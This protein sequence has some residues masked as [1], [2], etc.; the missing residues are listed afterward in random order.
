MSASRNSIYKVRPATRAA[1]KKPLAPGSLMTAPFVLL[2][3]FGVPVTAA[4]VRP[5]A[6]LGRDA[7]GT[8]PSE[9]TM[10]DALPAAPAG[11]GTDPEAG[12][13]NAPAL[14][15]ASAALMD[16]LLLATVVLAEFMAACWKAAKDF[17]AVGLIAK[18]IPA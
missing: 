12:V 4:P 11:G 6:A 8:D 5:V 15:D 16:A 9:V 2:R 10:G 17:C 18:T 7:V 13:G 3:V 14:V 1:R